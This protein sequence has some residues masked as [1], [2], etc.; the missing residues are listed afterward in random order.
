MAQARWAKGNRRLADQQHQ[1][2]LLGAGLYRGQRIVTALSRKPKCHPDGLNSLQAPPRIPGALR[3]SHGRLQ[4]GRQRWMR[5]DNSQDFIR[6]T[7]NVRQSSIGRW[8]EPTSRYVFEDPHIWARTIDQ[9]PPTT[10]PCDAVLRYAG[11]PL[12]TYLCLR[13]LIEATRNDSQAGRWCWTKRES[14]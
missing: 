9:R 10:A 6:W 4:E 13:E 11:H 1:E 7:V 5:R 8:M 2:R 14:R 12:G 3:P